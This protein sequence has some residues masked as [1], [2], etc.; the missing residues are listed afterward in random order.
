ML[1]ELDSFS[2]TQCKSHN[3]KTTKLRKCYERQQTIV[4]SHVSRQSNIIKMENQ[5]Q[6]I[7]FPVIHILYPCAKF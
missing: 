6:K 1:I 5:K 2:Y 4:D 3:S 7:T